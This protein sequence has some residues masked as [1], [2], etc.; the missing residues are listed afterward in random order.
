MTSA[1][2]KTWEKKKEEIIIWELCK[3]NNGVLFQRVLDS[4]L[5]DQILPPKFV[6]HGEEF[7]KEIIPNQNTIYQSLLHLSTKN[8][9]LM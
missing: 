6:S 7:S 1:K 4:G 3:N 5:P 8:N 2:P 9:F